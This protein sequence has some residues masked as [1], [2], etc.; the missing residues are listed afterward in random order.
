VGGV[1]LTAERCNQ[2]LDWAGMFRSGTPEQ[3]PSETE[4]RTAVERIL[5]RRS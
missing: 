5:L 2:L 4:V 1:A 3:P